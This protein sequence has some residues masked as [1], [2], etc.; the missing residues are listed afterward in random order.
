ML[1]RSSNT[2]GKKTKGGK[3]DYHCR[4]GGQKVDKGDYIGQGR[5]GGLK[6]GKGGGGGYWE[7]KGKKQRKN[8]SNTC[9]GKEFCNRNEGVT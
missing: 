5:N 7:G 9:E 2:C 3:A 4:P 1:K 6:A 8:R